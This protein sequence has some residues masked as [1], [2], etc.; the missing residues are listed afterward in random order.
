MTQRP[1]ASPGPAP[2]PAA[3]DLAIL[4]RAGFEGEVLAELRAGGAD[5]AVLHAERDEGLVVVRDGRRTL[6]GAAELL[7]LTF[8]RQWYAASP[9][10]VLAPGDRVGPLL[11]ALRSLAVPPA[12]ALRVAA[13]DGQT[14]EG[15][16]RL[17]RKLVPP[18]RAGLREAGLLDGTAGGPSLTLLFSGPHQVW[19]CF[20]LPQGS[21]WP[22]GIP[23]L[24]KPPGAPSRAAAKLE[25][26][27]HVFP[28]L[29]R[30][31]AGRTAVDL[32]AA[33]GGW[34]WV[35]AARGFRVTAVDHGRLAPEVEGTGLVDHV[36]GDAFT[37]E[38]RRPVHTL[39]ADIADKPLR[40][41][42]LVR[43]W[44][45]RGWCRQA[46]VNL[47]LPMQNR[48]PV[49]QRCRMVVGSVLPQ[50][51]VMRIRQLYHDRREVTLALHLGEA[52]PDRPADGAVS[53]G[54]GPERREG[55]RR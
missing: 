24:R 30:Q 20:Q 11:E 25:E 41:A 53:A 9:P 4:C 45:R 28:F 15:L 35:L 12:G 6:R 54:S 2:P 43:R 42:D 3:S 19:P 22:E 13:P 27:L 34:S 29:E 51:A 26:A 47:K 5:G 38:P 17:L 55:R 49:V 7:D 8:A 48:H 39:V 44:V 33:P 46:V 16:A 32:G 37:F 31:G 1:H 14:G 21:P 23:R 40:V 36:A 52:A 10:V 18:L 50:G